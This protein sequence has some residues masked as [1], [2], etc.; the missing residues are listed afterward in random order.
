MRKIEKETLQIINNYKYE[1]YTHYQNVIKIREHDIQNN[2]QKELE[3]FINYDLI[4]QRIEDFKKLKDNHV[5]VNFDISI[6]SYYTDYDSLY[7][8][9]IIINETKDRMKNIEKERNKMKLI[10][11]N[12]DIKSIEYKQVIEKL[13]KGK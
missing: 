4:S 5:S 7:E 12:S 10:L 2:L 9:D 13:K 6:R 11:Q 3:N 8:N 1:E